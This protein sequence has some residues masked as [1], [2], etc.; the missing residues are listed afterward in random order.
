MVLPFDPLEGLFIFVK[1]FKGS[2]MESVTAQYF[3]K[4]INLT[5]LYMQ[6]SMLTNT[7]ANWCMLG[8]GGGGGVDSVTFAN[9]SKLR[10]NYSI[11]LKY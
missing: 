2:H 7:S 4:E 3:Q 11:I 6:M 1:G 10:P 8:G 5:Q 9:T